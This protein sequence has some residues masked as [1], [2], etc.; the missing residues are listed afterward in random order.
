MDNNLQSLQAF[1][2]TIDMG[3]FSAVGRDQGISQSAVS[4]QIAG[5]EATLGMQ[6]FRRTTRK[7][8]PT[9][10]ALHL[11]PYVQQLLDAIDVMRSDVHGLPADGIGGTLRITMPSSFGRK[12]IMPLL[13]EFQQ[14][15]PRLV[16]ELVFA[17]GVLDLVEEGMELGIRIGTLPSSTLVTRSLGLAQQKLVATPDYLAEHGRPEVPTDLSHHRCITLV[18]TQRSARW[19]FE[20][21]HGRH[22][23]DVAGP[24]RMNDLDAIYDATLS[25]MGI[26]IVPEWRAADDIQSGK[27]V[28]LLDEFFPL[29][30]PVSVVYPQTRFLSQRARVFIDFISSRIRR[31]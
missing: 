7:L 2:R 12:I 8:S 16:L 4:K 25:H 9:S 18:G 19:E 29:P 11:Y 22:A 14:F 15:H 23:V 3:S 5:L 17:D 24:L 10:E 21:E 20:S 27:I 28:T 31:L 1:L 6:L 13:P 26:S 30:Q